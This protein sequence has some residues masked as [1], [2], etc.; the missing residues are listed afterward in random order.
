M[1]VFSIISALLMFATVAVSGYNGVLIVENGQRLNLTLFDVKTGAFDALLLLPSTGGA[2]QPLTYTNSIFTYISYPNQPSLVYLNTQSGTI[3]KSINLPVGYE[4]GTSTLSSD[5]TQFYVLLSG[6]INFYLYR[7]N[8]NDGS[9]DKSFEIKSPTFLS[10]IQ[11]VQLYSIYDFNNNRAVVWFNAPGMNDDESKIVDD[12]DLS[13]FGLITCKIS[14]GCNYLF[15][16]DLEKQQVIG[17]TNVG[18]TFGY[19]QSFGFASLD[20]NIVSG[21][22]AQSGYHPL[23]A[24]ELDITSGTITYIQPDFGLNTYYSDLVT[25]FLPKDNLAFVLANNAWY[26]DEPS[27]FLVYDFANSNS[28]LSNT[29]YPS[30][31]DTIIVFPF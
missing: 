23:S 10:N 18:S 7:F 31:T 4:Y 24:I 6:S 22:S 21:V 25:G 15:T 29:T 1:K 14:Q 26:T 11:G 27:Y 30:Q 3:V 28:V 19:D 16:L 17:S 2:I 9:L 12:I 8:L 5:G 20:G 13:S